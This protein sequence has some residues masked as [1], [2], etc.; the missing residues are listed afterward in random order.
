[1]L[2]LQNT[3]YVSISAQIICAIIS[4]I[5]IFFKL[6]K[7]QKILTNIL[8][9][10]T[11]VQVIEG[12]YYYWLIKN[13]SN[14]D[15]TKTRYYDWFLTT[16]TMLLSTI[17][18]FKYLEIK[19][20]DK[21]IT[22]L[23]FIKQY[24]TEIALIFVFNW[25]M[26]GVGYLGETGVLSKSV[27]IPLGFVFF[28]LSFYMI[29]KHF[30]TNSESLNLFN[31]LLTIWGLYGV[32]AIFSFTTKNIMYNILDIFSKNFYGIYIFYKIYQLKK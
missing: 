19:N 15:I 21:T 13:I 32:A 1:M 29:R 4:F 28:G 10:E 16:P 20:T 7:H 2:T 9:L 26:L 14:P 24:K 31:V 23:G 18:Y 11:F 12:I 17:I 5:G 3:A 30:V 25:I 8:Q 6:P 22:L 27:Y